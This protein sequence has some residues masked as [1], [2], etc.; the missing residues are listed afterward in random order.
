[1]PKVFTKDQKIKVIQYGKDAQSFSFKETA[2]DLFATLKKMI[3]K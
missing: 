1:M 2:N 3:A